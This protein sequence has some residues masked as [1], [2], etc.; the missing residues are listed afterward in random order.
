MK[1]TKRIPLREYLKQLIN[2]I[3]QR[4]QLYN[5]EIKINPEKYIRNEFKMIYK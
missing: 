1:L 5:D 3:V 2:E 4:E